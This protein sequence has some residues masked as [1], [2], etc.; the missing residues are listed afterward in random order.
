[1]AI[2]PTLV[3]SANFACPRFCLATQSCDL[4]SSLAA[5]SVLDTVEA[6]G[7]LA[8]LAMSLGDLGVAETGYMRARDYHSLLLLYT[9]ATVLLTPITEY[10]P[11]H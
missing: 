5:A 7:G 11:V 10:M 1:M 8:A 2:L 6:W 3:S 4:P 9:G